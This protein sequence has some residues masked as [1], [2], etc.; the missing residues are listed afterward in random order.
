MLINVFN[1]S[2]RKFL[3][4]KKLKQVCK[5]VLA[6]EKLKK[7]E[8]NV[9][10]INDDSIRKLNKEFLNHDYYTDVI[11]FLL[12]DNTEKIEGEVYIS[13]DTARKQAAEY[14]VSL[15][16]ELMRLTAHGVL[17]LSGYDDQTGEE[18][19]RMRE[20]ENKYIADI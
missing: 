20:L 5:A 16:N 19:S 7:A 9:V 15:Q 18:R 13:V 12:S 11:S 1:D 10:L 17:H 8:I 2:G 6:G 14:K 3:P 4:N